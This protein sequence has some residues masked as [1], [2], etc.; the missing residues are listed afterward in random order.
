MKNNYF[1]VVFLFVLSTFALSCSND[2]DNTTPTPDEASTE[3]K[4][5]RVLL[6]DEKT[7]AITLV[8]P[9]DA[10]TSS[11]NAKFA[12]SSLYT[13]ESGRYAGIVHR[14]DNTVCLLYTS[15][16]ADDQINV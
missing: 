15:D 4:Y 8:N 16:A 7:T 10:T 12:K 2:D 6:S 14:A 9:F 13:T 3:Y 1:K 11:F 5:L